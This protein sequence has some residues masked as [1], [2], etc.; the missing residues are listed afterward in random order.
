MAET[1]ERT[2]IKSTWAQQRFDSNER[3]KRCYFRAAAVAAAPRVRPLVKKAA[4][5]LPLAA[6]AATAAAATAAAAAAAARQVSQQ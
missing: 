1:Q 5:D 4:L 6:A 2:Q 3:E